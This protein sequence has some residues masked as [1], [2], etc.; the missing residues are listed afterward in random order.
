LYLATPT[1]TF[2][3][4]PLSLYARARTRTHAHTRTRAPHL[5][6][7]VILSF[8]RPSITSF[9]VKAQLLKMDGATP[10][11]FKFE[12]GDGL[13]DVDPAN[14]SSMRASPN[15]DAC[16]CCGG[17]LFG[18]TG[19]AS[20]G[21]TF[22]ANAHGSYFERAVAI[23]LGNGATGTV[24]NTCAARA[25]ADGKTCG[26]CR[27]IKL[28]VSRRR[29]MDIETC[30]ACAQVCLYVLVCL[31]VCTLCPCLCL[32]VSMCLQCS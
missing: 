30:N 19:S 26:C 12:D 6:S 25:A 24:C 5:R 31:C 17:P 21:Q 29:G 1:S 32:C 9:C 2:T 23:A 27:Q 20:S 28:K 22:T 3:S 18:S 14:S 8:P 11:T 16:V 4:T 10:P 15:S 7:P 13:L